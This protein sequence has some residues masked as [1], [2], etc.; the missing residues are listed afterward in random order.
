[1]R[2]GKPPCEDRAMSESRVDLTLIKP[3]DVEDVAPT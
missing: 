3:A 2:V 1:M